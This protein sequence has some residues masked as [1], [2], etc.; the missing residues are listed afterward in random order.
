MQRAGAIARL[1]IDELED[2]GCDV[3]LGACMENI[4]MTA[5][6]LFAGRTLSDYYTEGTWVKSGQL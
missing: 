1:V 4:K 5:K 6:E 3:S 2:L